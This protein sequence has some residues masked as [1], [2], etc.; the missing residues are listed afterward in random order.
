MDPV[1]VG[2]PAVHE[3]ILA[4]LK[5]LRCTPPLASLGG[6]CHVAIGTDSQTSQRGAMRTFKGLGK[7]PS[8]VEYSTKR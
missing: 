3:S 8:V 6:Q 5:W 4:K 1:A 2:R 7:D